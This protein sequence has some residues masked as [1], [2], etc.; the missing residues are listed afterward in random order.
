LHVARELKTIKIIIPDASPLLTLGGVEP[1][2]RE[3][4]KSLNEMR[5][6][7]MRPIDRPASQDEED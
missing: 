7:P 5:K 1:E 6:S 4:L 3:I 2:A